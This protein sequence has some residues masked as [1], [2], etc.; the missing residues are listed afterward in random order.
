LHVVPS[1]PD[2]FRRVGLI[3][4]PH[5]FCA[6]LHKHPFSFPRAH[7]PVLSQ[8][9]TES[10]CLL[11]LFSFWVLGC[12]LCRESAFSFFPLSLGIARVSAQASIIDPVP[13]PSTS[14]AT[15][16][17]GRLPYEGLTEQNTLPRGASSL[18]AHSWNFSPLLFLFPSRASGL[19]R[20]G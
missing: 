6:H 3:K 16:K 7:R 1:L 11:V 18:R 19:R 5:T 17:G 14:Q 4:S 15:R 20:D 8:E 13:R 12:F 9:K 10:V 2:P